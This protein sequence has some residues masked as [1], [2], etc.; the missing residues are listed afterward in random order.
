MWR[1]AWYLILPSSSLLDIITIRRLLLDSTQHQQHK[2]SPSVRPARHDDNDD[3]DD[4][5]T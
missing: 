2:C 1:R 3:D 5:E 4:D